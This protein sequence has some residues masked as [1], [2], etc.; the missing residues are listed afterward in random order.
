[1]PETV[2]TNAQIVLPGEHPVV[3]TVWSEG[4]RVI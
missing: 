2:L 4:E 3:R 1:M